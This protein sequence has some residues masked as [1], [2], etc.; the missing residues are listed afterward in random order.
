MESKIWIE[1][2]TE[3]QMKIVIKMRKKQFNIKEIKINPL[4]D[5]WAEEIKENLSMDNKLRKSSVKL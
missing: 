5:Q 4:G 3:R 2:F 1:L